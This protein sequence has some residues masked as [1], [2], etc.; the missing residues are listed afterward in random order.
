MDNEK[1]QRE[2]NTCPQSTVNTTIQKLNGKDQG[3]GIKVSGT[4]EERE[5][6]T[7]PRGTSIAE[8]AR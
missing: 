6:P 1:G 2:R 3:R 7:C 8:L 5:S 4:R